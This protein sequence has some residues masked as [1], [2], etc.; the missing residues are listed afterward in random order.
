[1]PIRLPS[2]RDALLSLAALPMGALLAL[3]ARA[4]ARADIE[5]LKA[6][7]VA[8]A[9]SFAGQGDPDYT[10]QHAL[11]GVIAP[12]LAAAPPPP[13]ADR[14][15]FLYGAWK[16]VW[17]PYDYRNDDRGVD[18][19][20]GL[21]EIYQV[22]S[23][24][25]YYHNVSPLYRNADPTRERIGLLKGRY[26]LARGL[27]DALQVRFVDYPGFSARPAGYTLPELPPALEAGQIANDIEIVP[28][29]VVKLFFGT[30]ALREVYTDADLR[31][32]YGASDTSFT[33]AY[34]Y[35]MTRA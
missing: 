32:V 34:L 33:D 26:R 10:I 24:D 25:G 2:R 9:A 22:V 3:P 20:L 28:S 7:V 17:G 35:V 11:E 14:L 31:L 18:P 13:V 5:A 30:G 27:D 29:A 15:P 6:E 19:N 12:L 21:D 23:P 1:M 16:Q 8:L 4:A